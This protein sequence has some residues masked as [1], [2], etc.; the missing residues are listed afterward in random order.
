MV[1]CAERY[2]LRTSAVIC[3]V[4]F[5]GAVDDDVPDDAARLGM[6]DP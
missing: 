4:D 5:I 6:L 3:D 1:Q 2:F